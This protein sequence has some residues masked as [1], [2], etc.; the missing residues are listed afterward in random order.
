[1][2]LCE[3]CDGTGEDRPGSRCPDCLGTGRVR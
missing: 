1:M 3:T 2:D